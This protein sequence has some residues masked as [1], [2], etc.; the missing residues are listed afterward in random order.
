MRLSF[1]GLAASTLLLAASASAEPE[2]T[3]STAP[4]YDIVGGALHV[5]TAAGSHAV[6]LACSPRAVARAGQK[7]YVACGAEGVVRL[8]L[9]EP[10]EPAVDGRAAVDGEVVGLFVVDN[11]VW[12]QLARVEA[13]PAEGLAFHAA[14][15]VTTEARALPAE[16]P[17]PVEGGGSR[18]AP[19]RRADV[20]ELSAG[21]HVFLPIGD[22]GFGALG[23]F[24]AAH[25]FSFPMAVHAELL[26]LGH[27]FG[28]ETARSSAAG[29]GIVALD[30]QMFEIGVGLGYATMNG[31]RSSGESISFAQSA[32][33]GARDGF[34]IFFRSNVTVVNDKFT[35]GSATGAFQLPLTARW[36][37]LARG[38]G[39]DIG[40]A[41]G[42]LGARYLLRGDGGP[43]SFAVTGAVGGAGIFGRTECGAGE[44]CTYASF[45]GPAVAVDV[46]FRL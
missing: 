41:F 13:R 16:S 37:L 25:R 8:D 33:I 6:R 45:S 23:R 3:A 21:A 42:D 1:F 35:L 19:P 24:E 27:A 18:L 40:F 36:Q 12:V 7:L 4:R 38:G 28:K 32:R 30:T 5:T 11:K 29:H 10:A 14:T 15:V 20:T 17:A 2:D 26:P 46:D 44:Y 39:G 43:G 22:L 31:S 34:A 9:A